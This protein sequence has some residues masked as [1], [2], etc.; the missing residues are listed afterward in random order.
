M[1]ESFE[2]IVKKRSVGIDP[3]SVQPEFWGWEPNIG[4][5]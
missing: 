3:M 1:L 2:E 4:F 5:Y